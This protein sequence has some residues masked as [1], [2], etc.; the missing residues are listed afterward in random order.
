[1]RIETEEQ[2]K[3]Y[4]RERVQAELSYQNNLA[5]LLP[6][7][8]KAIL[9]A[10]TQEDVEL[11]I[12]SL[13]NEIEE[14]INTLATA[15]ATEDEDEMKAIPLFLAAARGG[16]TM[17]DVIT[18]HVGSWRDSL[19]AADDYGHYP[20]TRYGRFMI[21]CGWTKYLYDTSRR[22][23]AAWFSVHRGSSYP[24]STCDYEC[25]YTH[26]DMDSL[27]PYHAHCCCY[28]IPIYKKGLI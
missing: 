19:Q 8:A 28:I 14:Y 3:R 12:R 5:M 13:I 15:K 18:R 17:R 1:M 6:K 23:G 10:R 11:L 20:L 9:K 26:K 21:A 7:Y 4:I 27:P 22:Q 2:A 16:E 24:C 25:S